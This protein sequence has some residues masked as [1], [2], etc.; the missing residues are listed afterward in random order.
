MFVQTISFRTDRADELAEL[1]EHWA[2]D[3]TGRR[4]VISST[5]L[6][7]HNAYM[8]VVRFASEADAKLNSELP[9]TSEMARK[10]TTLV[11]GLE[12]TNYEVVSETNYA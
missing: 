3:S 9:E 2:A 6:R 4:T 7:D 12:Y 5:L 1:H 11:T 8:I 10:M